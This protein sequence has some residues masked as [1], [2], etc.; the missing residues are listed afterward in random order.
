MPNT[1]PN[2]APMTLYETLAL[3][4]SAIAILIPII[5]WAWRKWAMKPILKFH[6][7]GRATLYCNTSGS[8]VSVEGIFEAL[9]K[10]IIVKK[11][12]V[13]IERKQDSRKLNLQWSMFISPINQSI[14][15]NYASSVETAHPFR[16]EADSIMCAFTEYADFYDAARKTIEPAITKYTQH[17]EKKRGS[18]QDPQQALIYIQGTQE[19]EAARN[20]L[21]KALYWE[22]GQY[23]LK[24]IVNHGNT[25]SNYKY[26]FNVSGAEREK[27]ESNVN[28]IMNS[29]VLRT[30]G[31][32]PKL[33][34]VQVAIVSDENN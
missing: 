21:M 10:P 15:G 32:Q 14:A 24:I 31:I 8:Y 29:I 6:P 17:W 2:I 11:M 34:S 20:A 30:Y 5:Q 3:I 33:Q 7:T 12:A 19:Y 26:T 23:S 22:I 9:H 25:V 27:F 28:E 18:I 4:M 16:V 1:T 13:E